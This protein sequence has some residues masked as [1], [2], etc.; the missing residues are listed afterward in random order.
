VTALKRW[1][2]GLGPTLGLVI[3][4][5]FFLLIGGDRAGRFLSAGNL[6]IVL[7]QTVIV[8]VAAIGMTLVIVSGGID[9][10]V[11]SGV[12]LTSVVAALALGGGW[13]PSAAIS[14]GLLA[15]GALG[16]LNGLL[17]TRLGVLPFV[18]TL[19]TLGIARGA[20]KWAA[21]EETVNVPP[22][23]LNELATTSPS[24]RWLVVSPGVWMAIALATAFALVLKRTVF[25]RRVFALGSNEAAARACGIRVERLK[26]EVY[27]IAGVLFGL[28]GVVQTSR[29]RQGDPTVAIGLELD[30]IA[31]V[32]IGGGSLDGGEGSVFGSLV[33]ALVMSFL[34][35]GCQLMG[36][37]TYI[38]EIIIGAIIVIAVAAD[39]S[40]R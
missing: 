2:R 1:L 18:A 34:R 26:V 35:N 5:G 13:A 40:R 32:V 36:W 15:G 4:I 6:R 8:A 23:W 14:C 20:A 16:L 10:S 39:R 37:P 19:G 28:A 27:A 17:V 24:A 11:G 33:G 12:A 21:G 7:A 9:L 30:V 29:L 3:T 25:G 38:Q 31:S 22:T